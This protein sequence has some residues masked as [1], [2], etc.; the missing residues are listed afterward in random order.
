MKKLLTFAVIAAFAFTSCQKDGAKSDTFSKAEIRCE[1]TGSDGTGAASDDFWNLISIA[2]TGTD[3]SGSPISAT[4]TKT[5]PTFCLTCT[6]KP[7]EG[8]DLE[9]TVKIQPSN[10]QATAN[11]SISYQIYVH[12]TVY[13]ADGNVL[14][15]KMV[16]RNTFNAA[17]PLTP[18]QVNQELSTLCATPVIN[19]L[20]SFGYF[21]RSGRWTYDIGWGQVK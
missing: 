16:V 5:N 14:S 8:K 7:T 13:D 19:K 18:A 2:V 11:C 21:E 10:A 4:I 12:T 9:A 1:V 17:V 3:F 15:E 20:F 6:E